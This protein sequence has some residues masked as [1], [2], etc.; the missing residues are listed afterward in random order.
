MKARRD[1]DSD[2]DE[3][4]TGEKVK[5]IKKN[6]QEKVPGYPTKNLLQ[7][8]KGPHIEY[9]ENRLRAKGAD[10]AGFPLLNE[11]H[12]KPGMNLTQYETLY[13]TLEF[14]EILEDFFKEKVLFRAVM[15]S[16]AVL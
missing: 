3:E 4:Y 10:P 1:P 16:R 8:M 5:K 14:H 15:I 7:N 13:R 6:S 2:S 12:A 9:I 11:L